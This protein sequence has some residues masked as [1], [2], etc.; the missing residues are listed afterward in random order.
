[1]KLVFYQSDRHFD[2]TSLTTS[3]TKPWT[4]GASRGMYSFRRFD[5]L[6]NR[7][8]QSEAGSPFWIQTCIVHHSSKHVLLQLLWHIY[9]QAFRRSSDR[10]QGFPPVNASPPKPV[11]QRQRETGQA[12]DH[13]A[14]HQHHSWQAENFL[15]STSTNRSPWHLQK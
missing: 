8:A 12:Q 1:M 13:K 6:A 9:F 3:W 11:E 5:C 10:L 7:R 15:R 4:F 2:G 14:N